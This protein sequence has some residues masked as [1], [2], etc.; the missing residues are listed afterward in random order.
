MKN[1]FLKLPSLVL[2]RLKTYIVDFAK[3]ESF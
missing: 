1:S 2:E 3:K